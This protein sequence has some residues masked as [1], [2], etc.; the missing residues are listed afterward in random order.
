VTGI[1]SLTIHSRGVVA[2]ERMLVAVVY[3]GVISPNMAPRN[4]GLKELPGEAALLSTAAIDVTLIDWML[5]LSPE[6]RLRVLQDQVDL[7][8]SARRAA[9]D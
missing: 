5:G 3:S 4:Q 1:C 8:A 2:R 7:I 9:A 6:D